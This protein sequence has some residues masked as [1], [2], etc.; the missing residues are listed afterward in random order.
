MFQTENSPVEQN[1]RARDVLTIKTRE[2]ST[3]GL[4]RRNHTEAARLAKIFQ[5][6]AKT[7]ALGRVHFF[8]S[9]SGC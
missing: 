4:L 3:H 2:R 5:D 6:F 9:K 7:D 8:P 1:L